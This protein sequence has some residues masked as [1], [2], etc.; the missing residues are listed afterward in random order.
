MSYKNKDEFYQ[1]LKEGF[2]KIEDFLKSSEKVKRTLTLHKYVDDLILT[3]LGRLMMFGKK[4]NYSD[5]VSF[6]AWQGL[7]EV[8][9][10]VFDEVTSDMQM[11]A[12]AK[13]FGEHFEKFFEGT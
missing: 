3:V 6:L 10:N 13:E 4:V 11:Y 9:D 8:A 7:H 12:Y 1:S 5:L 2:I